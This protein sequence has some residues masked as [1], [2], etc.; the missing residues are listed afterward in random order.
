MKDFYSM[1]NEV[2]FGDAND[3][4]GISFES[5]NEPGLPFFRHGSI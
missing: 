2:G 1:N 3:Y 4:T 5:I